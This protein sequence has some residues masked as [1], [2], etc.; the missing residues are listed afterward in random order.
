MITATELLGDLRMIEAGW[1]LVASAM[2][3]IVKKSGEV[4]QLP[5]NSPIEILGE[6]LYEDGA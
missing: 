1:R 3:A 4:V 5:R 2:R 6:S